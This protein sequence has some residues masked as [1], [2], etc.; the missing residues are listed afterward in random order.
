[1]KV[2]KKLAGAAVLGLCAV[3]SANAEIISQYYNPVD[4]QITTGNPFSYT[5]NMT[6]FG[7]PGP[8]VNWATLVVDLYDLTDPFSILRESVT[9]TLNGTTT[10]A[11][12]NVSFLGQDYSFDV[13]ALLQSSGIVDVTISV[14]CTNIIIACLPQDVW[15]DDSRLT[16]D[17][18]RQ[19]NEVPEPGTL[20]MLGAG[21][22][23]LVA[24]RRRKQRGAMPA[25]ALP[26]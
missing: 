7:L 10:H 20:F 24:A 12:Q 2:L 8:Q 26:A 25:S 23:G 14:S 18:T 3:G 6:G 19:A 9:L 21:M 16:A 11:I 17:I 13:A 5:H 15:F 4:V 1:M 22:L